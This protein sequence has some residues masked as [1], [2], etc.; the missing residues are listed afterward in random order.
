M[1]RLS[2]VCSRSIVR[3]CIE[4]GKGESIE[5]VQRITA[6]CVHRVLESFFSFLFFFSVFFWLCVVFH[7][8]SFKYEEQQRKMTGW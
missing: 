1:R 3:I 2:T 5:E 8:P 7:I 6:F 4:V